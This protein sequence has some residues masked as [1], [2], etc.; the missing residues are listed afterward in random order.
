MSSNYS[1]NARTVHLKNWLVQHA[2]STKWRTKPHVI[3]LIAAQKVCDE[4]HHSHYKNTYWTMNRR[5]LYQYNWWQTWK[6][7]SENQTQRGE[8]ESISTTKIHNQARMPAF[9]TSTQH[10]SASLPAGRQEKE[11]KGIQTVHKEEVK[12]SLQIFPKKTARH[13]KSIHKNQLHFHT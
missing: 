7:H 5:K 8:T 2:I 1:W 12:L 9:I 13:R 4:F 6:T 10:G 3:I 11:I